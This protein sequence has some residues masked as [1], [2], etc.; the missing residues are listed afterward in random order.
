MNK[1]INVW[2]G[3]A[4][5]L[6]AM[7]GAFILLDH[8][9]LGIIFIVVGGILPLVPAV[10]EIRELGKYHASIIGCVALVSLGI[11]VYILLMPKP[12]TPTQATQ[13][14]TT[15]PKDTLQLDSTPG[16]AETMVPLRDSSI[17]NPNI[18]KAPIKKMQ[19]QAPSYLGNDILHAQFQIGKPVIILVELTNPHDE[20]FSHVQHV[21]R[22]CVDSVTDQDVKW[23]DDV[24]K[25]HKKEG[26]VIPAHSN[27]VAVLN[28]FPTPL[29]AV[30]SVWYVTH[31]MVLLLGVAY[32]DPANNFH[33]TEHCYFFDLAKDAFSPYPKY[34]YEKVLAEN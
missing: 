2:N 23:L 12:Q 6:G 34:N 25:R 20:P 3:L 21:S 11:L 14:Q 27:R 15:R 7:G 22:M 8:L 31:K 9:A 5:F 28:V 32:Y 30:D 26:Y 19:V 29:S 4:V 24:I 17:T 18:P 33:I 16:T 1:L 10:S 13:H